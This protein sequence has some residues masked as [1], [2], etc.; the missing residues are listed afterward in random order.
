[1]RSLLAALIVCFAVLPAHAELA[2]C[3]GRE[4]H[5]VRT[6]TGQNYDPR[7][8]TAAMISYAGR[9]VPFGT[10]VRVTNL[11]NGRAVTVTIND[12][13]PFVRGRAIDLSLGSCRA[14]GNGGIARVS[15]VVLGR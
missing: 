1:M 15:L 2:S 4:H 9:I 8:L 6:A 11:H 10:K 5:Q 14:I 7:K 3:Y 12:R 13:G